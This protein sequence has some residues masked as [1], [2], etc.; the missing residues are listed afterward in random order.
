MKKINKQKIVLKRKEILEKAKLKAK[1]IKYKEIEEFLNVK[2]RTLWRSEKAYRG[3]WVRGLEPQS[4]RQN[5][6]VIPENI[7]ST[8]MLKETTELFKKNIICNI[9][10][11]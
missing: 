2:E 9:V 10:T 7:K 8:V 3:L 4:T 5:R 11:I 1:G 6:L